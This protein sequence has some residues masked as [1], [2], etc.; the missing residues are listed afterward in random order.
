MRYPCRPSPPLQSLFFSC[1]SLEAD[2]MQYSLSSSS[3]QSLEPASEDI[4]RFD[5]SLQELRELRTQLHHAADY[6]EQTFLKSKEKKIVMENTKEY[7]CKAM[8][9]VVD[10]LGAVSENLNS[11]ISRTHAFSEA[12]LRLNSLKQRLLACEQYAN[13]LALTKLRWSE[14]L[15]RYH[16]RYLS[17]PFEGSRGADDQT[18]AK[19]MDQHE[20]VREEDVPLF[21][22][23]FPQKPSLQKGNSNSALVLPV[24]DAFS[25]S[26]K[27]PNPAFHFQGTK[28]IGR[29]RR[30]AQG[31]DILALIRRAK[32]T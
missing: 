12:E 26:S 3:F 16:R 31:S 27:R 21:L 6:S 22:Y 28:E 14:N 2:S 25:V 20:L 10:H 30:L 29:H 32:R 18:R 5:K 11:Y 4:T 19:V 8:V 23:T 13:K 17:M 24:R 15:K 1:I 7:V 9:T